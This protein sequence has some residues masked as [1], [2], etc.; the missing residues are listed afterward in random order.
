MGIGNPFPREESGTIPSGTGTPL[1]PRE[2]VAVLIESL[3]GRGAD[4]DDA[5]VELNI[6]MRATTIVARIVSSPPENRLKG[7]VE[8]QNTKVF[9]DLGGAVVGNTVD[10]QRQE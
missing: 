9:S 5:A 2:S 1:P 6:A 10:S 3:G 7:A 4:C 8:T